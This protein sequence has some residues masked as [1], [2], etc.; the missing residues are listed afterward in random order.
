MVPM[1]S[2]LGQ[3]QAPRVCIVSVQH[4]PRDSRVVHKL[5]AGLRDA[6]CQ[7]IWV[8]PSSPNQ[9]GESGIDVRIFRP[10]STRLQRPLQWVR[11]YS[12]ARMVPDVDAYC[13]VSPDSAYL[14]VKLAMASGAPAIFDLHEVYHHE[15]LNAWAPAVLHRLLGAGVKLLVAHV[16]RHSALVV[17]SS[18]RVLSPYLHVCRAAVVVRNCAPEWF[19]AEPAPLR[20]ANRLVVMHGKVAMGDSL[21]TRGTATVLKALAMAKAQGCDVGVIAFDNLEED[22]GVDGPSIRRQFLALIA[23][24]GIGCEVEMRPEIPIDQMPKALAHVNVGIIAY[25]R[26]FGENSL[27]GRLFEYMAAAVPVI[28]PTYSLDIAGVIERE[29]CGLLADCEDPADV[30]RAF[31][32][33]SRH[34]YEA[35][36]M[37]IRG[38][39]AFLQRYCLEREILPLVAKIHELVEHPAKM[40]LT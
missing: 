5:A 17:A 23:Q 8:G 16:A 39:A 19:G 3:Q 13:G 12:A 11:A 33:L 26:E 14:A 18:E 40:P 32:W 25:S 7:V 15:M 24:L 1:S 29:Q 36:Q 35:E 20:H 38:R 10:A 34:Q 9:F 22:T 2:P 31:C 4:G 27:P 37:G 28:G 21:V 6:G 30:A